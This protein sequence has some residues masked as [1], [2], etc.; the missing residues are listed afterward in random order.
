MTSTIRAVSGATHAAAM[1]LA[2]VTREDAET[3]TTSVAVGVLGSPYVTRERGGLGDG[4][5]PLSPDRDVEDDEGDGS[6]AHGFSASMPA[7][8]G[9]PVAETDEIQAA[10]ASKGGRMANAMRWAFPALAP[11]AATPPVGGGD[12]AASTHAGHRSTLTSPAVLQT[13]GAAAVATSMA[14]A[15]GHSGAAVFTPPPSVSNRR[16]SPYYDMRRA[17]DYMPRISNISGRM[18]MLQGGIL[19]VAGV[20]KLVQSIGFETT[21]DW[22]VQYIQDNIVKFN[23]NKQGHLVAMGKSIARFALGGCDTYSQCGEESLTYLAAGVSSICRGLIACMGFYGNVCLFAYDATTGFGSMG[24]GAGAPPVDMFAGDRMV[25]DALNYLWGL[26]RNRLKQALDS[27]P[28]GNK[29]RRS[30]TQ[31][32]GVVDEVET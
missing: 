31:R 27:T 5:T 12:A 9:R 25:N 28:Y 16:G 30:L 7:E 17:L 29:V 15:S 32:M 11:A 3:T 26:T 4:A 23:A 22:L 1:S 6:A 10:P 8:V 19:V 20:V 24:Q 18:H 14:A 2:S 21:Y 13:T